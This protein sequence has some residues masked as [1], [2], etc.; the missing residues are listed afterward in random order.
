MK[1]NFLLFTAGAACLLAA[2]CGSRSGDTAGVADREITEFEIAQKLVSG[3]RNYRVETDYGMVYLD[4]YTSVQWPEKLGGHDIAVLQDSLLRFAYN[5]TSST[6][7]RDAVERFI[8]GTDVMQGVKSVVA[9]DSLPSGALTYFNNAAASVIDLEEQFISYRVVNSSYL[10][11]AHPMTS[12][13]PFTYDLAQSKVLGFGDIFR[14]GVTA[15]TVMPVI[16]EALA[17]QYS[18]PVS[19]LEQA[20][21]FMSAFTYPGRPYIAGNV[22]YF[23]YDPYEIGPYSLGA[24]DVAVYPYDIAEYI[25]PEILKLFDTGL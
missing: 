2:S 21:F 4:I 19:G 16:R 12:T 1:R 11:G 5:D 23:H 14:D 6:S 24:V 9:V 25:R 13:V 20:G 7:V 17:R 3:D 15:D 10:G 8:A 18:V 22:L